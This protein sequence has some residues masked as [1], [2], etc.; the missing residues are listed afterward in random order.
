[1]LTAVHRGDRLSSYSE[2]SSVA[3]PR[4]LE[5]LGYERFVPLMCP[6]CQ[7]E[8]GLIDKNA[9]AGNYLATV[10]GVVS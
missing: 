5:N 4:R 8:F 3:C 9:S 6:T 1:M 2:H 10:H 7:A